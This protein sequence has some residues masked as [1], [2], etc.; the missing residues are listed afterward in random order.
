[1]AAGRSRWGVWL[2]SGSMVFV[3]VFAA[4]FGIA[5]LGMFRGGAMGPQASNSA[6]G[7]PS[8]GGGTAV[9]AVTGT[10]PTLTA[11]QQH[12]AQ[13]IAGVALGL[14][15][16][17]Q[18]VLIGI[19]AALTESTLI[20]VGH[21]DLLGPDS[22]GLFQERA[23]WGP[24]SVRT[25][26]AGA[27]GLFYKGGMGGQRGLMGVPGWQS[28]PPQQAA[29][30]VEQ[31]EFSDGSNYLKNLPA[32]TNYTAALMAGQPAA[33]AVPA[34]GPTTA[35]VAPLPNAPLPAN[36]PPA[37]AAAGGA[38]Y[39]PPGLQ[40]NDSQD[41][42]T[43]GWVRAGPMEPLNYQGHAFGQVAKG[44]AK[45]WTA[46]LTELV[47]L[48]PGGLDSYLGAYEN[49]QNV[50]N[51]AMASFHS[52]GLAVDINYDR[53]PNGSSA[54]S[55]QGGQFVLPMAT[56]DVLAKYCM[57]WGG[58]FKGTP[59]PMHAEIHCTPKQIATWS[60]TQP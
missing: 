47:P 24:L 2:I 18:G 39:S 13:V 56:H 20:N 10:I 16:G 36:C 26:P 53:N 44:T 21:G 5:V 33:S 60:A 29:Q 46:M 6:C 22:I 17:Q 32:A 1:M 25:D 52:F 23:P 28:M 31:S 45:L 48:I 54:Q 27:A 35:T 15:L 42:T 50:N 7:T 40:Q 43:F 8:G 3:F 41:P 30:A 11:E 49:R 4:L 14:G 12:N 34:T 9:V 59:D 55:L 38:A 57:A 37:A 51:P 19:V 58:D